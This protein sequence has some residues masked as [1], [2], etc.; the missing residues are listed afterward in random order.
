MLQEQ[1][2][3]LLFGGEPTYVRWKCQ[4]Q[5]Q[6]G[7]NLQMASFLCSGWSASLYLTLSQPSSPDVD[8]RRT[9]VSQVDALVEQMARLALK[10]VCVLNVKSPRRQPSV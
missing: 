4:T 2:T 3:R 8:V 10:F 9:D 1:T 6:V 7:G 5:Q